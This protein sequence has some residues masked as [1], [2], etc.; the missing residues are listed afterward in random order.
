MRL[1]RTRQVRLAVGEEGVRIFEGDE[2]GR[3]DWPD[4]DAPDSG[5]HVIGE[6]RALIGGSGR[7]RASV[8]LL[9]PLVDVRRVE[10]PALR[11]PEVTAVL[12]NHT[13]RYF[14]RRLT[15][16]ATGWVPLKDD[17]DGRL[18]LAA[19]AEA[20]PVSLL[21]D[22]LER[23]GHTVSGPVPAHVGWVRAA[24]REASFRGEVGGSVC[25]ESGRGWVI[26]ELRRDRLVRTTW[27]A[28]KDLPVL[29]D[30]LC[31][32][33]RNGAPVV[34]V[35]EGA[36]AEELSDA[37]RV[38]TP[39]E[40]IRLLE[41]PVR[42]AGRF[43]ASSRR[44]T[45]LPRHVRERRAKRRRRAQVARFVAAG[46]LLLIAAGLDSWRLSR[47]LTE[48]RASRA[49]H[50][51]EVQRILSI[52]DEIAAVDRWLEDARQHVVGSVDWS[53][54]L[55]SVAE[56][57]PAGAHLDR[58]AGR[59]GELEISGSAPSSADVLSAI[60]A[61][62]GVIAVDLPRPVRRV[63]GPAGSSEDQ[64]SFVARLSE[65]SVP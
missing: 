28:P 10:L 4:E 1:A 15:D 40:P 50:A 52:R 22:A 47:E 53:G 38:G 64:F 8:V 31:G 55:V 48:V 49:R 63:Q 35:G 19:A 23:E 43:A 58:I 60:Q 56:A 2:E 34:V 17:G 3:F 59:S 51:A 11:S 42:L 39:R 18:V 20:E 30:R 26:L 44:L 54:W 29:A 57:L 24:K 6:I 5:E 16:V 62:P 21:L 14:P 9:P 36:S 33:M 27:F 7:A 41:D 12:E 61:V 45:V 65:P 25:V 13:S 32:E 46:L 37:L